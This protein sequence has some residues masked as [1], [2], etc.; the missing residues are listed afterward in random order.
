MPHCLG[1]QI[2]VLFVVALA[3]ILYLLNIS[4]VLQ[5]LGMTFVIAF[6][7]GRIRDRGAI[8]PQV[9]GDAD[10]CNIAYY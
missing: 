1:I 6:T 7:L 4:I 3:R 2:A 9:N 5:V 8:I 10:G